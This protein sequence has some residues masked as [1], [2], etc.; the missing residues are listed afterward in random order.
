MLNTTAIHKLHAA[1][2]QTDMTGQ[3]IYMNDVILFKG[4]NSA[5]KDTLA[6]VKKVN[7]KSVVVEISY[8]QYDYGD[9]VIKPSNYQGYWDCYPNATTVTKRKLVKRPGFDTLKLSSAFVE[10]IKTNV[11]TTFD[12]YPEVLI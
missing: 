6:V 1:G 10:E 7:K 5:D 2:I 12:A 9:Y 11:A 8:Q 4:Y 3:R